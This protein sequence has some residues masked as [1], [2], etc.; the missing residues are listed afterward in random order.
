MN[1]KTKP[2]KTVVEL[3]DLDFVPRRKI[4]GPWLIDSSVSMV[5]AYRG[6]GKTWFSLQAAYSSA[7]GEA[8]LGWPIPTPRPTLFI[9][10]EMGLQPLQE[11]LNALLESNQGDVDERMLSFLCYDDFPDKILPNMADPAWQPFFTETCQK[12]DVVI[13]DNLSTC[14]RSMGNESDVQ[15]WARFQPWLIA[16]RG[17]GKAIVLIH[18]SGKNM[19][20]RGTSTKEDVLDVV[21]NLKKS[22]KVGSDNTCMELIFEK[23]RNLKAGEHDSLF[24]ELLTLEDGKMAWVYRSLENECEAKILDFREMGFSEAQIAKDLGLSRYQVRKILK[25]RDAT[26]VEVKSTPPSDDDLF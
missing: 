3:I 17:E 20:Q 9:D 7:S 2:G 14:V 15:T 6:V 21:I 12:Y 18:H 19:T 10:G 8:F 23:H 11:R 13:I 26:H 4:L 24:V 16:R 22:F 1:S 25:E 5:H